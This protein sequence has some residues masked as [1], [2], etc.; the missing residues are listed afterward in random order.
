MK[1]QARRT[2]KGRT[3]V[4]KPGDAL[5]TWHCRVGDDEVWVYRANASG[6]EWMASGADVS[7][8]CMRGSGKRSWHQ[9]AEEAIVHLEYLLAGSP[10]M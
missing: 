4:R 3:F 8:D 5:L 7:D 10:E 2:V 9:A 6:W 1:R